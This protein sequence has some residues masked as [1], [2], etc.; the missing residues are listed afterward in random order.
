MLKASEFEDDDRPRVVDQP[1]LNREGR[2]KIS[3]QY[4]KNVVFVAMLNRSKKT[5]RERWYNDKR[6]KRY[7]RLRQQK[8]IPKNVKCKRCQKDTP[9]ITEYNTPVWV[10]DKNEQGIYFCK[11]CSITIRNTELNRKG[12]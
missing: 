10:E 1:A 9:E 4:R 6:V 5:G 3:A 12:S 7:I 11:L 2:G 8:N